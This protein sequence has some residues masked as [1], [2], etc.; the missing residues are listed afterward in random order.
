[1]GFPLE[2]IT[3][4]GSGLLGGMMTLWGMK[5]KAEQARSEMM[6]AGLAAEA[7][8]VQEART[9]NNK[10]Y[11][12]TR[13]AIALMAVASI[14]VLPKIAALLFPYVPI[15]VGYTEF[16]PGFWFFTDGYEAIKWHQAAGFV[17]TPLDTHLVSAITGLYFG[18]SVIRNA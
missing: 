6:I 8:V 12:F 2:L 13:R 14:I 10:D 4:L 18:S 1:M 17:I 7:K 16:N 15:L 9:Y 11:Q 3:L 5:L